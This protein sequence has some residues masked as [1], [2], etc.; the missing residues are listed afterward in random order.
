MVDDEHCEFRGWQLEGDRT[1][2]MESYLK[3]SAGRLGS[4]LLDQRRLPVTMK[5]CQLP[6]NYRADNSLRK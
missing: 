6:V 2:A 5:L 3:R 1:Q 4:I